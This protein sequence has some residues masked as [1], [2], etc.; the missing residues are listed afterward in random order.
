M[1]WCVDSPGLT[2]VLSAVI[3]V[4]DGDNAVVGVKPN[5]PITS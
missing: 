2:V 1:I 4:L 5:N 3:R